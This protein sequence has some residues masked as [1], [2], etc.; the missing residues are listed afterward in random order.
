MQAVMK[1]LMMDG[2]WVVVL[3]ENLALPRAA[4]LVEMMADE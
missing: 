1:V 3:A 4:M 2:C